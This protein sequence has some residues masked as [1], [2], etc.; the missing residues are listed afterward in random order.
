MEAKKLETFKKKLLE[1]KENLEKEMSELQ[2]RNLEES[3]SEVSGENSYN[4]DFADSG[5]ATFERERDLSLEKNIKDLIHR[6]NEA[7]KR[8]EKGTYGICDSCG[9]EIDPARL[10]ALPYVNLCIE[11]KKKEETSW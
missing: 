8:I 7:L 5:T 6:V 11:C 3:Q 10:K 9:K 4:E 2:D 1:E